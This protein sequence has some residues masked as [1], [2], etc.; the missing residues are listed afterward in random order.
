MG[1]C[2]K[3]ISGVIPHTNKSIDIELNGRNLIIT[4]MNGTGKTSLLKTVFEKLNVLVVQKEG[5]SLPETKQN[6]LYWGNNLHRLQKGTTQYDSTLN[7]IKQLQTKIDAVEKGLRLVIPDS[8]QLSSL[9]DDRKAVICFFEERHFSDITPATMAK[10]LSGEEE[11]AQKQAP[12][13]RFGNALEQHLVNLANRRQWAKANDGNIRKAKEIDDWFMHFELQLKRLF[14]D[15]SARLEI[16][17]DTLKYSIIQA[18]KPPYTFQQLSAGYR[19][20]FDIYAELLMRTEYFKITPKDLTGVIFIDEIDAHLHVSLQRLILPFFTESFPKIQFIVTSHSPFVL[21][22]TPDTMVFDLAQN[23]PI[24]DDLSC[25]TYSAVMKGLWDLKPIAVSLE[26]DIREIAKIVNAPNKDFNRLET[27][28]DK[29][30]K[31]ED[32]LDPESKS[33]LLMGME[34]LEERENDV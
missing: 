22:S 25:Y 26:N 29:I 11:N 19:A 16:D 32:A 28:V 5:A 33:F 9:Y 30:K 2:I 14:E 21:M 24:A 20:I 3:H 15:E 17:S 31:Y 10:G 7:M 34:A 18:S 23:E 6:L 12:A 27:L 4:G 1:G 8:I 13:K